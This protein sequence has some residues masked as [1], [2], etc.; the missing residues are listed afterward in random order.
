MIEFLFSTRFAVSMSY[1]GL[2]LN[3]GHLPGNLYVNMTFSAAAEL[4]GYSLCFLCS[5]LGRKPMHVGGMV[6]GGLALLGTILILYEVKDGNDNSLL[7]CC[8]MY[9][10]TSWYLIYM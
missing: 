4:V 5:K 10:A 8:I 1:Y 2:S 3:S 7:D 9:G 6:I